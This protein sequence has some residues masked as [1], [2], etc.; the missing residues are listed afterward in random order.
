MADLA[1]GPIWKRED[2]TAWLKSREG[3]VATKVIGFINLKGG[4]G[5]TTSTVAISEFLAEEFGK[6][7]LVVDLDPQ[8]K[9]DNRFDTGRAVAGA[10]QAGLHVEAAIPGRN[11]RYGTVRHPQRDYQEGL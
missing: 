7:V 6:R 3:R 2:I 4:V 10:R 11:S 1:S 8:N 9:L 5:K